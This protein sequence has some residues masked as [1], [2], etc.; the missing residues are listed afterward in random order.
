[1][2]SS[3]LGIDFG[4]SNSTLGLSDATGARLVAL[5]AGQTTLPSAIFFPFDDA[6]ALFGR[7]AVEAYVG[8]EHGRLMRSLKSILGTSLLHEKTRIGRHSLS[9]VDILGAFFSFL[10]T[11][12]EAHLGRAADRVVLGR[13]VRFVDDDDCGGC[14]GRR[15]ARN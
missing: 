10:K 7:A 14:G 3:F 1:M 2:T 8:G 15:R 9:F 11:R 12:A 6:R 5:E 4:T 13:P